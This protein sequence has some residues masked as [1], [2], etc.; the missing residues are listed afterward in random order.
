M[1][2]NR[3]VLRAG[4]VASAVGLA[5]SAH[6]TLPTAVSDSL[7]A[8][9][10]DGVAVATLVLVAIVAIYAFKLMRKGL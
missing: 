9:Q 3:N 8:A 6:A 5:S 7:T 10:S 1:F 4:F 2:K